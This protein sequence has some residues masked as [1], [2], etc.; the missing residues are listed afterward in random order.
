MLP[1]SEMG[2][3]EWDGAGGCACKAEACGGLDHG[4]QL[5][6]VRVREVIADCEPPQRV[7][8]PG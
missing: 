4:E 1:A 2:L 5:A 8:L 7:L 6:K 3:G